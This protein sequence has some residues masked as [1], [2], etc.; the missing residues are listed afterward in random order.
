MNTRARPL[1]EL[2]EQRNVRFGT[3]GVRGLVTDLSDDVCHAYAQGFLKALGGDAL[4]VAVGH[5]LRPSS[6]RISAACI[7]TIRDA[8]REPAYLGALPTPA[9]ANFCL[10][11]GCPGIMVTGSHIPFDRNGI[12]FYRAD[13]EISKA[14]E[15]AILRAEVRVPPS[16]D[17]APLPSADRRAVNAYIERYVSIFGKGALAGRRVALYEHTGMECVPLRFPSPWSFASVGGS[18]QAGC[19]GVPA[20]QPNLRMCL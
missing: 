14:D 5:D 1:L 4:Q 13:G 10:R 17:T 9:L 19:R 11:Q 12:K 16:P 6:P 15:E 7:Q 18:A 20:R 8:G 2:A 3:S